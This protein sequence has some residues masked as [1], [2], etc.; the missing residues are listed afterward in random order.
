MT[1]Y[2]EKAARIKALY[3]TLHTA[4]NKLEAAHILSQCDKDARFAP[5]LRERHISRAIKDNLRARFPGIIVCELHPFWQ[6]KQYQEYERKRLE[7]APHHD[8][9]IGRARENDE[10]TIAKIY[11][12]NYRRLLVYPDRANIQEV[13]EWHVLNN[14][15][16]TVIR[17]E[18]GQVVGFATYQFGNPDIWA[19]HVEMLGIDKEQQ[20]KGYGRRLIQYLGDLAKDQGFSRLHL[21]SAPESVGFY[22][23]NGFT[24]DMFRI[25]PF[26]IYHRKIGDHPFFE[27]NINT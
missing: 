21:S 18:S 10:D 17:N 11:N 19:L 27:K 3:T 5:L 1:A 22:K 6:M 25:T 14:P 4:K 24:P 13:L 12:E 2:L 23:K 26:Q 8:Q 16:L 15:T 20:R 9:A 7:D